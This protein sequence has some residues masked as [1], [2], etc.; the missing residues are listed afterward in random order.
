MFHR[1]TTGWPQTVPGCW[2]T[3]L[4]ALTFV[5]KCVCSRT[6]MCEFVFVSVCTGEWTRSKEEEQ[7]KAKEK[8]KVVRLV[9]SAR[10]ARAV[11]ALVC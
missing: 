6:S 1:V 5:D 7:D 9:N 3:A 8:E 2:E 4:G 10:D 11:G